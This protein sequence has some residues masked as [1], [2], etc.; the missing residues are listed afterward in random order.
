MGCTLGILPHM[1]AA[2][3]GLAALLHASAVAFEAIKYAGV[4]YLLYMAWKTLKE[5]GALKIKFDGSAH[6]DRD[7]ISHAILVNMLNP[8]LSIFF[9]AFLPQFP[10]AAVIGLSRNYAI[11][12]INGAQCSGCSA[13]AHAVS[14]AS[15]AKHQPVHVLIS[16]T[17]AANASGASCGRLWP[18]FGTT[19]F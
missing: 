6:S 5:N 10:G 4:A 2:I 12:R 7:V 18:A 19:R 13:T 14:I 1:V 3:T 11:V 9:F 17:A 15:R 8:K 16:R